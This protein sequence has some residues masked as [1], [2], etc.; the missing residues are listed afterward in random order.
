MKTNNVELRPLFVLDIFCCAKA[1]GAPW[2]LEGVGRAAWSR[3]ARL[4]R[5]ADTDLS[6]PLLLPP[7]PGATFLLIH[8]NM[9]AFWTDPSVSLSAGW[10]PNGLGDVFVFLNWWSIQKVDLQGHLVLELDKQQLC[11]S[12]FSR[13]KG[14]LQ[15]CIQAGELV[16]QL[17]WS[18]GEKLRKYI[19]YLKSKWAISFQT[20]AESS[21][22]LTRKFS[23]HS[24]NT[25]QWWDHLNA[26]ISLWGDLW[27][28][29]YWRFQN[30]RWEWWNYTLF[31]GEGDGIVATG[32]V[33]L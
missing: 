30:Q 26:G 31:T 15:T 13:P 5:V 17:M 21:R 8:E 14:V 28:P 3:S 22:F 18:R 7:S 27:D 12:V 10:K 19:K 33:F 1:L 20:G 25:F 16:P 23:I 2:G 6:H 9:S 29:H 4:E 24:R 11:I 32:P